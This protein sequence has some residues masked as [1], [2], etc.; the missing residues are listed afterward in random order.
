MNVDLLIK[1]NKELSEEKQRYKEMWFTANNSLAEYR[2]LEEQLGCPLEVAIK[3][4]FNNETILVQNPITKSIQEIP[5]PYNFYVPKKYA[6]DIGCENFEDTYYKSHIW[7]TGGAFFY[8]KDYKKTW[9]LKE[10]QS[11]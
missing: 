8:L 4:L 10:D 5:N 9:W 11:E 3:V 1:E 6:F 7:N 2:K